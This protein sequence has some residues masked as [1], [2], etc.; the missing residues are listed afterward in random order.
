[1][2]E[3]R[4]SLDA[5]ALEMIGKCLLVAACTLPAAH[6]QIY[7]GQDANGSVVLSNFRSA[8]AA[9]PVVAAPAEPS[10]MTPA[11]AAADDRFGALIRK[12]A[13]ETSLSPHLLHAVI[14]VESGFDTR[15]VSHKGAMGLMQLMPQTAQRFGVRDPFDPQQNIAAGA[16]YLKSLLD[17][18]EGDLQLA[19]AAYNAG[20]AAVIKAG[21]QVPP[22]AETRAYVPRV[23]AR[24]PRNSLY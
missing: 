6:A 19:L 10:A 12:V 2:I 20:E 21:Y 8:L 14:A 4:R 13:Q 22:Y 23:L 18:F 16:A 24:L 9:E 11:P 7:A 1:M 17:R 15:A 3:S 5:H